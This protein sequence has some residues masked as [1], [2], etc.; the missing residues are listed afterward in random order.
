MSGVLKVIW[1]LLKSAKMGKLCVHPPQLCWGMVWNIISAWVPRKCYVGNL[2][3][4]CSS[5]VLMPAKSVFKPHG[6]RLKQLSAWVQCKHFMCVYNSFFHLVIRVMWTAFRHSRPVEPVKAD[7]RFSSCVIL[8]KMIKL[9]ARCSAT[10]VLSV[11]WLL[12]QTVRPN[13]D[14]GSIQCLSSQQF[15][16][17]TIQYHSLAVRM[18]M[19]TA[20]KNK[21]WPTDKG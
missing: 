21:T 3:M 14:T 12:T 6:G 13:P 7:C 19:Q 17:G 5:W 2:G 10:D 4:I 20:A 1:G 15:I 9:R 8:N 11:S 18:I 16:S